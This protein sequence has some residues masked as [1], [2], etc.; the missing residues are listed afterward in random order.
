[1]NQEGKSSSP[2]LFDYITVGQEQGT[3]NNKITYVLLL[4]KDR[5]GDIQQILVGSTLRPENLQTLR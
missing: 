2:H 5:M 1:M 4:E 3:C